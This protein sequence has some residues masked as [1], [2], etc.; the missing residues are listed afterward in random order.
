MEVFNY[1]CE[2]SGSES[3]SDIDDIK[4]QILT[5]KSK[6]KS[7]IK[8]KDK[9]KIKSKDKSKIKSKD[10]SKKKLIINKSIDD[11]EVTDKVLEKQKA[12]LSNKIVE[13]FLHQNEITYVVKDNRIFWKRN[14]LAKLMGYNSSNP[15]YE[16]AESDI[17][18]EKGSCYIS[19]NV[20]E[21][22]LSHSYVRNPIIIDVLLK[23]NMPTKN[24]PIAVIRYYQIREYLKKHFSNLEYNCSYEYKVDWSNENYF[25]VDLVFGFNGVNLHIE[26]DEDNHPNTSIEDQSLRDAYIIFN[27]KTDKQVS[28][29]ILHLDPK[30]NQNSFE[31]WMKCIF[32]TKVEKVIAYVLYAATNESNIDD[33]KLVEMKVDYILRVC[34]GDNKSCNATIGRE[35]ISKLFTKY[36]DEFCFDCNDKIIYEVIKKKLKNVT[37]KNKSKIANKY[38]VK[39]LQKPKFCIIEEK[40]SYVIKNRKICFSKNGLIMFLLS[41]NTEISQDYVKFASY[42]IVNIEKLIDEAMGLIRLSEEQF[43]SLSP[44]MNKVLKTR[45]ENDKLQ[46]KLY[47]AKNELHNERI[48]AREY[49]LKYNKLE[50][51]I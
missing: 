22:K 31:D 3:D 45:F 16:T 42:L 10:K 25:K 13:D 34:F 18:K 24:V 28:S 51:S 15:F 1:T 6:D 46:K 29:I 27:D 40:K 2:N 38:I 12:N 41:I 39:K 5:I 47:I 14:E 32:H 37:D 21:Y 19:T 4:N 49:K 50:N 8:S 17:I 33:K 7:K 36:A 30:M 23:L 43:V 26:F 48:I 35:L 9:S 11:K 44:Y 20:F